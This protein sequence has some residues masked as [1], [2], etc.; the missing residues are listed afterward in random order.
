MILIKKEKPEWLWFLTITTAIYLLIE[1]AFN[2]RLLDVVSTI[3]TSKEIENIE[4]YG[5]ALSGFAV[6]LVFWGWL[7]E[8]CRS[9]VTGRIAWVKAI[10]VI[11]LASLIIVPT[12]SS[13]EKRMIDQLVERSNPETR[14]NSILVTMLQTLLASNKLSMDGF[15][16]PKEKL[17]DPDNKAFL[18]L[19][20]PLVIYVPRLEK[21][22]SNQK[23]NISN[24][25]SDI[26]YG[27]KDLSSKRLRI[28]LEYL[29]KVYDNHFIKNNFSKRKLHKKL[30]NELNFS[31]SNEIIS[32]MSLTSFL[33]S[34]SIQSYL[35]SHFDFP[36][37][38]Y[39][40]I[41]GKNISE[42]TNNFEKN[43]YELYIV[44][45]TSKA[46]L[47]YIAADT[48]S[49]ADG[50]HYEQVGKSFMHMMLA[51]SIALAFS[52]LGA[53]V[54]F[55]KLTFF[56]LQ[57]TTGLSFKKAIYKPIV[58]LLLSLGTL[59]AFTLLATTNITSQDLY[60][61]FKVQVLNQ[62]EGIDKIAI[63]GPLVFFSDSIIHAQPFM[64]P[65][66]EW[67]RVE[68]FQNLSFGYSSPADT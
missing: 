67:V 37:G 36:P 51:P 52:V 13:L 24:N 41:S 62:S 35:Q 44:T 31:M 28:H 42:I 46:H 66:F 50:N 25:Y 45:P 16:L 59:Y 14:K 19:Y 5:R 10:L 1:F 68:I 34:S 54:H 40:L 2:A 22:F 56:G 33:S 6:A 23:T 55:W 48:T 21:K 29:E 47:N 53:L 57:L 61:Y 58:I 38:K 12:V 43:V 63:G 27:G 17:L 65:I 8:K 32:E 7:I 11:S 60:Q 26:I 20:S 30:E 9:S 4:K 64:Y 15:E 18:T 49:F 39:K 3:T